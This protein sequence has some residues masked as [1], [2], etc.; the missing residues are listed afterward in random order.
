MMVILSGEGK[1]DFGQC[2]NG[3]GICSGDDYQLGAMAV[4]VDQMLEQKIGYSLRETTPEALHFVSES[5]LVSLGKQRKG[6]QISLTSKTRGHETSYFYINAWMLG[7]FALDKEIS[8]EDKAIAVLFRDCDG[9]RSSKAGLW[10]LKW[11]SMMDG[12]KSAEFS[13]GVP[14]LPKPKSEA[15]LICAAQNPPYQYCEALENLSGNDDSP[16]SAKKQ[17]DAI[18]GEHKSA[19]ALCD[20]LEEK[21]FDFNAFEMPS[22][23]AFKDKLNDVLRDICGTK[24]AIIDGLNTPLEQCSKQLD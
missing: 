16:N 1:T 11:Q 9:T 14:M 21:P 12:F 15:W 8:C 3:Q 20:W 17:L 24:Q 6:R 13:R 19:E 18:F 5:A 22:F 7:Q 2:I 4:L 23:N 10:N